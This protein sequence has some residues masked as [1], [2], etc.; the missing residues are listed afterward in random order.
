MQTGV[1]EGRWKRLDVT[2]LNSFR[3]LSTGI[4]ATATLVTANVQK[5]AVDA[6]A[7]TAVEIT[8]GKVL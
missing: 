4:G 2:L 8:V 5:L 1:D 7:E 6:T 3:V